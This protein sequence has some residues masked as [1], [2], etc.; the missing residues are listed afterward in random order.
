[1]KHAG[2]VETE[3]KFRIPGTAGVPE[4]LEAR[5]FLPVHPRAEERS[6]LW[7]REG[8]LRS[9][10]C[11]LRVRRYGEQ[12][13]FTWKGARRPD[14]LLKVRPEVE[15]AVEDPAALEG[16]LEALGFAKVM[17]MVKTRAI[18]R[19]GELEACLDEAPFGCF[20]E[21][22]GEPGDIRRAMEELGLDSSQVEV[23]S[24][25][26]LFLEFR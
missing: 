2:H 6:A 3:M 18:W 20:L 7:D 25:P 10:G 19:R 11:A 12:A 13:L 4:R 17:E 26:A 9:R 1:M 24:Y 22:E 14:P 23:R 21:L 8:Q 5:G 15:T 16:I